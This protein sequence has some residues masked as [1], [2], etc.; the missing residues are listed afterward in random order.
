MHRHIKNIQL[1]LNNFNHRSQIN[2][3]TKKKKKKPYQS[4][5]KELFPFLEVT[6]FLIGLGSK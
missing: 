4:T 6:K 2:T 1:H 3:E 5:D